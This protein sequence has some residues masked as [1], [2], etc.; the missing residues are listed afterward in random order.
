MKQLQVELPDKVADELGAM[1]RDGW[2]QSEHE[3]VRL[4]LLEFIRRRRLELMEEFQ[5]EDIA[6]ALQQRPAAR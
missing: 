6:W 3:A 2:F 5:R 4:A 1:V